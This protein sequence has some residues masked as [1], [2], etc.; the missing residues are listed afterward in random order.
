[1]T[2]SALGATREGRR[3]DP[4]EGAKSHVRGAAQGPIKGLR[5]EG[6]SGLVAK[7]EHLLTIHEHS[8]SAS[9]ST[10]RGGGQ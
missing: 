7:A 4:G 1:M 8:H 3:Q 10:G 2:T 6:V 9:P 5:E